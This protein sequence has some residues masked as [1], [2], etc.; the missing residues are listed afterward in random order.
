MNI[1]DDRLAGQSSLKL[2]EA[3]QQ[4][5]FIQIFSKRGGRQSDGNPNSLRHY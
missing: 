2:G 1:R 5:A 4:I 3:M